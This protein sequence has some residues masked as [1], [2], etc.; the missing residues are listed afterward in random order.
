MKL[1]LENY[2]SYEH[3]VNDLSRSEEY[4]RGVL[5]YATIGHSTPESEKK[6]GMKRLVMTAGRDIN[7]ILSKPITEWSVAA[8]YLALHPEGIGALNFRVND[9]KESCQFL[10]SRHATFLYDTVAVTTPQGVFRQCAIATPL[11]DV[12]FRFI[13]DKEYK[14]FSPSFHMEEEPGNFVSEHKYECIDHVTSNVKS[15]Q[16]LL[17]FYKEVLGF[18]TFWGIEFHTNDINPNL[19]VGSGLKSAVM[20]H[21]ESGIK[22]ANNEP[23]PPYFRNSQID[24]Y[25]YDNKGPGIQHLAL[26]VPDIIP[27]M[28]KLRG[29]GGQFLPAPESYYKKTPN[30]LKES[31]FSGEVAEPMGELEEHSILVDAS[32]KGYLLQ[33]FSLEM[34]R[35]YSDPSGGPLFYEVIQREGDDGFGGGNFRALFETIEVDQISLEKTAKQLPLETI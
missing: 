11:A 8:K 29:A 28:S 33:I 2:H 18:E 22:F 14:G 19:P 9:L 7:V 4:Y 17:A 10:K 16:P 24:I 3:Y 31:G 35:Q 20:W 34:G 13:E 21:K 6:D 5:G 12:I 26:R 15:L 1:S 30:R 27:V 23:S 32:E 25:L